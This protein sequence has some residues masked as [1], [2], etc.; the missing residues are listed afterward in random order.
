MEITNISLNLHKE[1]LFG[2]FLSLD[3]LTEIA[4]N[5]PNELFTKI[6]GVWQQHIVDISLED[7]HEIGN[8]LASH[9]KDSLDD[10]K[11]ILSATFESG[12][13]CQVV[14]PQACER[15]TVSI[16]IR[17]PSRLQIPHQNYIDNGFYN[18]LLNKEE[19]RNSDDE[20]LELYKSHDIPKFM[21]KCVEYGKTMVFVGGTGSGKTTY[22]KTLIAYIPLNIRLVTI[23]DNPEI[24]FF[25]H[26]NYVNLFYPSESGDTQGSIVTPASLLRANFRMNPDR[27]L[28]TEIRGGE[29]WD[30][31]KI[32]SSGHSGSMTSLHAETPEEAI[33][34][35]IER[36]YMNPECHNLPYSV[37][38]RKVMNCIDIIAS[39]DVTGNV[40][41][42]GDIY[43]KNV[44]RADYIQRYRN[45][46]I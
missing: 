22:M 35:I 12:E 9:N 30:F 39:V 13:R 26:K 37:L 17:K 40:R 45:E 8:S 6:N 41:R 4:V 44:H 16:T 33:D 11:P 43:F 21:E 20:L 29:T 36:C 14:I 27:I 46:T 18:R 2:K 34:G 3:G 28:L 7:C 5:R 32:V 31:M 42:M 23:E 19:T 1:K 25:G 38:F 10:T 15:D 24:E